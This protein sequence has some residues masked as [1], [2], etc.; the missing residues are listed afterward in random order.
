MSKYAHRKCHLNSVIILGVTCMFVRRLRALVN[1]G[2]T[3][4]RTVCA[5]P[6]RCL[7]FLPISYNCDQMRKVRIG[8]IIFFYICIFSLQNVASN[9]NTS[10]LN[11]CFSNVL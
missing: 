2:R 1:K 3:V 4:G 11:N 8:T 9:F 5:F 10:F 7:I 6:G